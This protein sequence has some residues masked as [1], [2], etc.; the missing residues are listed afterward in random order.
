LAAACIVLLVLLVVLV[1]GPGLGVVERGSL[2]AY[3][4]GFA[5]VIS[6]IAALVTGLVS[7]I[8]T[9]ER[10]ILAFLTVVVMFLL[11][12]F[13]LWIFISEEFLA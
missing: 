7:I 4:L 9:N 3:I 2:G 5:F 6:D 12:S 1:G 8:K 11:T 10:S 13:A